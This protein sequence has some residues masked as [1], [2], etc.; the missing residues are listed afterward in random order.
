MGKKGSGFLLLH[1]SGN[2]YQ[3]ASQNKQTSGTHEHQKALN[4]TEVFESVRSSHFFVRVK[5]KQNEAKPL[6]FMSYS[7]QSFVSLKL[8]NMEQQI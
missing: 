4:H 2:E 7:Q 3:Y 5:T 8:E 6:V 1:S